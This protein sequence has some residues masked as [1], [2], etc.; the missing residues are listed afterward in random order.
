MKALFTVFGALAGLTFAT[1][2]FLPDPWQERCARALVGLMCMGACIG[3]GHLIGTHLS[4][5]KGKK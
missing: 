4:E 3:F 5:R 2:L 1:C